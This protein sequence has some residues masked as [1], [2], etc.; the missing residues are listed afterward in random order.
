MLAAYLATLAGPGGGG[1]GNVVALADQ[2]VS[3]I[4][5]S[6]AEAFYS[7]ESTGRVIT[8]TTIDGINPVGDW[9]SPTSAA[10]GSYEVRA[11]VVVGTVSGSTTGSWLALSSSRQWNVQRLTSGFASATL[12]ISIR[13]A[14]VTLATCTVSL[15]AT[16][17]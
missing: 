13:L 16:A 1:G 6:I 3:D 4:N 14:G 10:P 17:L 15:E 2:A 8:F 11:D 7:L 5:S 12:T 9:I